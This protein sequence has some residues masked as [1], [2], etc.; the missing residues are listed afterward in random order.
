MKILSKIYGIILISNKEDSIRLFNNIEYEWNNTI[1]FQ[2]LYKAIDHLIKENEEI[3]IV[4][5]SYAFKTLKVYSR[6]YIN[7]I[8]KLSSDLPSEAFLTI[9][10]A[11]SSLKYSQ[12]VKK[13]RVVSE[14]ILKLVESDNYTSDATKNISVK[15]KW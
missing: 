15:K 8:S 13:A 11:L 5:L 14:K 2:D 7:R 4:S 6:D 10:Q 3:N 9:N 1:F 12:D